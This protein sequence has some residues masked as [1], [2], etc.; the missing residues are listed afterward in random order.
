[1]ESDR[2][3]RALPKNKMGRS[4]ARPMTALADRLRLLA[5]C[6]CDRFDCTRH[7]LIVR[8]LSQKDDQ[9]SVLDSILAEEKQR[10]SQS[11]QKSR[12]FAAAAARDDNSAHRSI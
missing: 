3:V 2:A 5:L 9:Y 12:S 1:M 7:S 4:I 8:L 10:Q 6:F 11:G